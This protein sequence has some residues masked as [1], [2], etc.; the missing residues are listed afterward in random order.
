MQLRMLMWFGGSVGERLCSCVLVRLLI[1]VESKLITLVV[2]KY[3]VVCC[4]VCLVW[5]SF[6]LVGLRLRLF[7]AV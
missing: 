6:G 7:G 4:V 5:C 1:R 3:R 2:G